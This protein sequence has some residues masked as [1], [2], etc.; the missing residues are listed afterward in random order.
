[1]SNPFLSYL[2]QRGDIEA[3]HCRLKQAVSLPEPPE[4]PTCKP[5]YHLI[6]N[7][8]SSLCALPHLIPL[9][10]PPPYLPFHWSGP[11]Y[12]IVNRIQK[13]HWGATEVLFYKKAWVCIP[14]EKYAK[15]LDLHKMF[16]QPKNSSKGGG[17]INGDALVCGKL[18]MRQLDNK[19]IIEIRTY[20]DDY[21]S[22]SRIMV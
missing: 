9:P 13:I 2:Y 18:L 22:N 7:Y 4:R 3:Q 8:W 1:M 12:W 20:L 19:L 6:Q 11:C 10:W 16:R 15:P 21:E 5:H 14:A 17:K